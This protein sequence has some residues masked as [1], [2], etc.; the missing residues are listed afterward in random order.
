[1]AL[2]RYGDVWRQHNK[3]CWQIFNKKAA[4][5]Y[6]SMQRE[7]VHLFLRSV[8]QEPERVFDHNSL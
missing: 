4:A 5:K 8:L 6:H 1:M 7:R 2:L 3:M